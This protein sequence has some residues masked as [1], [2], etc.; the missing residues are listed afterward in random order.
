MGMPDFL[1]YLIGV[2]DIQM[3]KQLEFVLEQLNLGKY[4]CIYVCVH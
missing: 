4:K 1:E 2:S 3:K